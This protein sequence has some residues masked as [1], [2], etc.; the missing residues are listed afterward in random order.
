LGKQPIKTTWRRYEVLL[1]LNNN[2]GQEIPDELL[3]EA[4]LEV[5]NHFLAVRYESQGIHGQWHHEGKWYQDELTLLIVDVSNT[6]QNR[7][8]LKKFKEKWKKRLNQVEL[9][10]VSYRIEVE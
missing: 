3:G 2:D 6:I 8:W 7:R 9:W 10:M 4:I 5:R 1:P